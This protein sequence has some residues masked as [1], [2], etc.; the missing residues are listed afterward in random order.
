[1]KHKGRVALAPAFLRQCD[2]LV[3]TGSATRWMENPKEKTPPSDDGAPKDSAGHWQPTLQRS[4]A[5]F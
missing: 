4:A 3:S 5:S 1:M 2:Q